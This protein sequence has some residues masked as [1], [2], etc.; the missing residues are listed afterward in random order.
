MFLFGWFVGVC[1]FLLV[2]VVVVFVWFVVVVVP[3]NFLCLFVTSDY[4]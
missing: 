1:C 4:F 3:V 2:F